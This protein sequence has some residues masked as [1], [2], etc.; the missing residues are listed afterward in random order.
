[1]KPEREAWIA[2]NTGAKGRTRSTDKKNE[3]CDKS[4][5]LSGASRIFVI[6]RDSCDI[7][8]CAAQSSTASRIGS[9]QIVSHRIVSHRIASITN[10]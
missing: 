9:N 7:R 10:S 4:K 8:D 3:S 5:P 2:S 1:M 6:I